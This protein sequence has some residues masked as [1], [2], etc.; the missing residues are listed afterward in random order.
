M[1]LGIVTA[2]EVSLSRDILAGK[3]PV[4]ARDKLIEML[5][6]LDQLEAGDSAADPPKG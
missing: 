3:K 5:E 4:D 6:I 1:T 2:L